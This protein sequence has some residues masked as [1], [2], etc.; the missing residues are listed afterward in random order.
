MVISYS[1]KTGKGGRPSRLYRLSDNVIEL[2]FPH[3]DYK[4][5]SSI[6]I[7][8]LAEMGENGKRAFYT[9]GEKYGKQIINDYHQT[10]ILTTYEKLNI[11]E[12]AST[13]LGMYSNFVYNEKENTMKFEVNNCPFKELASKTRN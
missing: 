1:Q 5:L 13:M 3:R 4:L 7:E 8:S 12:D 2:N 11:L 10:K 6:L 9:T